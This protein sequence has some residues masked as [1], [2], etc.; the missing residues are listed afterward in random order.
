MKIGFISACLLLMITA[1]NAFAEDKEKQQLRIIALAPHIVE[2]LYA[3]GA[4][5]QIIGTTDHADY[6]EQ[7]KAIPRVGN[8]AR[9]QIEKILQMRPDV[10]IAWKT[11]NPSDDLQRLAQYKI[12]VVYSNPATL[13]GVADEL[14]LLGELTGRSSVANAQ[15][16]AYLEALHTLRNTY[17]QATPVDVFYELWARPLRSVAGNAWPQQQ[18]ALCGAHNLFETAT[19]DYPQVSLEKVVSLKPKVIIQPTSHS[20]ASPDWLDWSQWPELPAVANQFIFHPDADK[21]HRMT[22]RMLGEVQV[23][24]ESIQQAREFYQGKTE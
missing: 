22:T 14:V 18:L 15:A 21:V 1:Q 7:A 17:S 12:N 3:I 19:D 11:G 9:L 24:C 13:E 6:P 10:V 20:G 23:M 5:D 16:N 2:S 4:G 8:Y